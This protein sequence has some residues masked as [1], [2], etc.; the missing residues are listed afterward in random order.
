MKQQAIEAWRRE[1]ATILGI[2]PDQP[3]EHGVDSDYDL[4]LGEVVLHAHVESMPSPEALDRLKVLGANRIFL[5]V[6]T[7]KSACQHPVIVK[8]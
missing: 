2:D 8:G 5:C 6:G 3:G 1:M 4:C 7:D